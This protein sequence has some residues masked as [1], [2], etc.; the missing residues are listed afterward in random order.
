MKRLTIG[1]MVNVYDW[2]FP[3]LR[4]RRYHGKPAWAKVKLALTK[5]GTVELELVEHVDGDSIYQDFL[6]EQGEG[7]HHLNFMVD[8]MDETAE[9][10]AKEG[11]PSIQSGRFGPSEQ[12]GAYNYID[13]KPLRAIWEA[14]HYPSNMGVEPTRYPK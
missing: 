4:D 5:V 3:Q 1:S 11:F 10:L 12:K 13:T 9:I 8:D 2:E 6:R 14:V 7:L